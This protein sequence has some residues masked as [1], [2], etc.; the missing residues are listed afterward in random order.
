MDNKKINEL[1]VAQ[2]L[3]DTSI[4][5][6]SINMG[7]YWQTFKLSLSALKGYLSGVFVTKTSLSDLIGNPSG[8]QYGQ[9]LVASDDGTSGWGSTIGIAN[10]TTNVAGDLKISD[11]P[12]FADEAAA[13]TATL[14]S[15]KIYK[16]VTGELRIKL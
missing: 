4:L 13:V 1:P 14:A 8:A 9:V 16:T 2:N 5:P 12:T 15:G 6:I 11:I 10:G 7:S 3:G